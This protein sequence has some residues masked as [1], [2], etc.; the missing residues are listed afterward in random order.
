MER[1]RED[2]M[3]E[4]SN[5]FEAGWMPGKDLAVMAAMPPLQFFSRIKKP[6]DQ[7]SRLRS[8]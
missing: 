4:D 5:G 6:F 1:F 7:H 3:D 8:L 2:C